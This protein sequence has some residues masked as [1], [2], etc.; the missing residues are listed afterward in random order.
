MK[1][2]YKTLGVPENAGDEDIRKAFR[3]L[4]FQYHPDKNIGHEKEAE[5]KFKDINEAYAVL[6]DKVKRQQYDMALKSGM[7]GAA[8]SQSGFQYSQQDIFRDAF[9]NR[10]SVDDLNRMFAQAGLRFDEDFLNRVFFNANN[11]VFKVYTYPGGTTRV[12]STG[13]VNAAEPPPAA[14]PAYKPNFLERWAARTSMKLSSFAIKKLFGIQIE[15]PKPALDVV[16]EFRLSPDEARNGGEKFFVRRNGLKKK[17]LMVKIPAGIQEGTRI[18]L[19]GLGRKEGKQYGDLY[20]Q[21]K[22][23]E[24]KKNIR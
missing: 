2:Y 11:L 20:L 14:E 6:S 17:K 22:I 12:Y 16:E 3:N 15:P 23:E 7:A 10:A 9:N 19:R 21:V 13:N 4:A 5:E 1:D 24:E 18:R 8:Y